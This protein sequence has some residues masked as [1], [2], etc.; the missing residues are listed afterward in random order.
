M[1]YRDILETCRSGNI[2]ESLERRCSDWNGRECSR[3]ANQKQGAKEGAYGM[4]VFAFLERWSIV[5]TAV[6][7]KKWLLFCNEPSKNGPRF[8]PYICWSFPATATLGR[9]RR[10]MIAN[11]LLCRIGQVKLRLILV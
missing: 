5:S 3:A 4:H 8:G 7:G 1:L 11:L 6:S 2:V 10:N 9:L